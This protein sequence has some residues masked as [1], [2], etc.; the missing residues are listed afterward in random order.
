MTQNIRM[1]PSLLRRTVTALAMP[2]FFSVAP[3]AAQE[4]EGPLSPAG[5]LRV[6]VQ[7]TFHSWSDRFG[8]TGREPLA[9][10]L[11]DPTGARLFPGIT[12]LQDRLRDLLDAPGYTALLGSSAAYVSA[13]QTRLPI[14]L[15]LGIRDWLTIGLNVPLVQSRTEVA[16]SFR[17]DTTNANL[18]VSPAIRAPGQVLAF[19]GDVQAR[20]LAAR[21]RADEVCAAQPG[22]PACQAALQVSQTGERILAGFVS[23]YGASPF[24]PL[25]DTPTAAALVDRVGAFNSGLVELG[26]DPLASQ[27]LF[28]QAPLT[29]GDIDLLMGDPAVGLNTVPLADRIG[30]WQL[31]D[32]EIQAVFRLLEGGSDVAVA[33]GTLLGFAYQVGA[34]VLVRLG[35]GSGDDPDIFLDLAGGDGQTDLEGRVFANVRSGRF[36][37]WNDLRYGVQRPTTVLRRIGPSDLVFVPAANRAMVRWTPGNYLQLELV[38]RY[39]VTDAIAFTLGYRMFTKGEDAYERIS[40]PIVTNGEGPFPTPPIYTDVSLLEVGTDRTLHEL[41][42]GIVFSTLGAA[43]EGRARLPFEARLGVHWGVVGSGMAPAGV[44]ALVGLRVF[45]AFWGN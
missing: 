9:V 43:R 6:E 7:P 2:L 23:A 27:P 17:A 15:D 30:L 40:A 29:R 35:T 11:I 45:R 41:G 26:L 3:V 10:D 38:P 21:T 32:I 1:T 31:G 24:F 18:G 20:A 39:H 13:S 19:V 36:G 8:E 4:T 14:R 22:S 44:R 25:A 42:G 28:A 34:G 16:F 33:G 12:T 5:R 37:L